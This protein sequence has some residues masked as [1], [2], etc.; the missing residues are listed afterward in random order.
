MADVGTAVEK[1]HTTDS[2]QTAAERTVSNHPVA[3]ALHHVDYHHLGHPA[4]L[5]RN[6]G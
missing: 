5:E 4:A 2:V 6:L 3:F 1:D